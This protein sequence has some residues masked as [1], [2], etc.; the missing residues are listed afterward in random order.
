MASIKARTGSHVLET[1]ALPVFPSVHN[2]SSFHNHKTGTINL[3]QQQPGGSICT[4]IGSGISLSSPRC[5]FHFWSLRPA[6]SEHLH[7]ASP[8]NKPKIKQMRKSGYNYS[9]AKTSKIGILRLPVT[10]SMII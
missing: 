7:G 8:I 1:S 5:S 10:I 9:T 3:D 2:L 4:K 6:G